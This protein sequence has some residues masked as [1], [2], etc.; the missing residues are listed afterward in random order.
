[1]SAV[2]LLGDLAKSSFL[3]LYVPKCTHQFTLKAFQL[4]P[5]LPLKDD[6][7]LVQGDGSVGRGALPPSLMTHG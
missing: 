2:I 6:R 5:S 4:P 7:D 1:M 3:L